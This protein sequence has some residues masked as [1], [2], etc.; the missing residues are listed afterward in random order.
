VSQPTITLESPLGEEVLLFAGLEG[1]DAISQPFAYELTMFSRDPAIKATDLLGRPLTLSL[2]QGEQVRQIN[3]IITEFSFVDIGESFARYRAML[4]PAL[5]LLSLSRNNRIFQGDS[6]PQIV[7]KVL[8][9]HGISFDKRG[10]SKPYPPRDYCVQYGESDLDFVQRLL[11]H[12]GILYFFQHGSGEHKLVLSDN[13]GQLPSAEG[14][15]TLPWSPQQLTGSFS[16]SFINAWQ[17]VSALR[18]GKYAHTDY[19]FEKPSSNLRAQAQDTGP[20]SASDSELYHYPGHYVAF[21]RG[22]GLAKLRIEELQA[23]RQ[24]AT[25]QTTAA[26]LYSGATFTLADHPRAEENVLQLILRTRYRVWDD[27]YAPATIRQA[28]ERPMSGWELTLDLQPASIPFRPERRTPRPVM[29]GPQ[30]A[31]VVGP[32]GQEIFTDKYARVK[33]QFHWDRLN[34]K[35]QDSSCWVRV[36]AAWAGAG[37]GFIQIPRIGQEVIVDFL[38]GDPDQPIITGRVYNAEQM[39]PYGLPGSATQSG[40]KSN[41]SPGGGGWNELRF[42]DKKGSEEVYFQAEKDHN[43]LVKNDETRKIG[44]DWKEEVVRDATQDVG[45]DR[46]ETVGN[47]KSTE[48]G[49]H[50][51]VKIGSNDT[52]TVGNNRALT[53]QNDETIHIVGNSAENIDKNHS[54]QV[55]LRQTVIVGID[56]SDAV[57][58]NEVRVVGKDRSV[59]V[60]SN[61]A[62]VVGGDDS[63]EVS[64]GQSFKIGKDQASE[65]TGNQSLTVGADQSTD[66]TGSRAVKVGK[67]QMHDVAQEVGLKSG[68]A[69]TIEAADQITLK[70]GDASV[71]LK[72]DGTIAI[73][74]K[75]ITLT[76]SGRISAK[77]SSEMTL[78][79]SKINQN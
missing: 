42:E 67:A 73:K 34:K 28:A 61:Q 46:A 22:D 71:V 25:A 43:E 40:W 24:R 2:D 63:T 35:N 21:A 45:H 77:A 9:P 70:C 65:V 54:Q 47:D 30:T 44:R 78:K 33:V 60:G 76:G 4:R 13:S 19:D 55:Q 58:A 23:P 31:V 49:R 48:V 75:D 39:P 8:K 27:Q 10:L 52:E 7:E 69:I 51:Q 62:H 53:V 41:S 29:Q 59:N 11:E 18:T 16:G 56:R 68:K 26:G 5:W 17:S 6:V 12:E 66:V 79:G 14:L 15:D 57:G 50:R 32:S 38:E 74:G 37:W 36:S 64:G 20:L 1:E 3:G 72:K